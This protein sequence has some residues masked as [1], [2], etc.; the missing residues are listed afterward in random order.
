MTSHA[1]A[2]VA[3]L[4]QLVG[5][6]AALAVAHVEL[7]AQVCIGGT[8]ASP[9][10]LALSG[11]RA[12][13]NASMIGVDVARSIS[14]TVALF[15]DGGRTAYPAPD[16]H[17]DRLALGVAFT[18][19]EFDHVGICLTPGVEGE[20]IGDLRVV[21]LPVGV[22]LG[23][24]SA[25]HDGQRRFGAKVEPFFVYSRETV[26]MFSHTSRLVSGRAAIV[27][28]YH[29]WLLGL[30][31]EDAFDRDARWHTRIRFGMAFK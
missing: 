14:R 22:S 1:P 3:R 21:R 16:P 26:A 15:A 4:A 5:C 2:G 9:G 24:S 10:W 18:F 17:R 12:Y 19:A 7:G 25:S 28:S 11:G 29:R 30:E 27:G 8:S 31:H 6:M 20:R 23:W 13:G